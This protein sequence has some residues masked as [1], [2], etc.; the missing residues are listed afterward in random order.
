MATFLASPTTVAG[1]AFDRSPDL[2][3]P[4][5]REELSG[6]AIKGF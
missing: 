4:K 5:V 3:A 2:T 1:Y 6:S